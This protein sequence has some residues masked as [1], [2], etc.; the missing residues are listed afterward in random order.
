M[1]YKLYAGVVVALIVIAGGIYVMLAPSTPVITL[2]DHYDFAG[3]NVE[4]SGRVEAS[5][6]CKVQATLNEKPLM[7]Q[8]DGTFT[9]SL[10]VAAT[11]NTGK[12]EVKA[13]A[14]PLRLNSASK[15]AIA[16]ST[17]N[18]QPTLI[19]IVNPP[20]EWGTA[21]IEFKLRGAPGA[22]V[23]VQSSKDTRLVLDASGN[24]T[25]VVPFDTAYNVK[26]N[27]FIATAKIEGYANGYKAADV[28]NQKY[29]ADR[30]KL[31]QMA[32]DAKKQMESFSG[33]GNVRVAVYHDIVE[34]NC[35]GYSCVNNPDSAKF[36]RIAI[37]VLNAGDRS[38]YV[39]PLY[40]TLRS[41]DGETYT[42]NSSTYSLSKPM[43]SVALQPGA[44]T[45]GA[46]AFIVGRSEK[47]FTLIYTSPD[48]SVAKPIVVQ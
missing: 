46:L 39:N 29:D 19:D 5:C 7:L 35:I 30:T 22:S 16:H 28:K 21:K 3:E 15:V 42:H 18:R 14:Q 48:G 23:T 47:V 31:E 1:K 26:S 41:T 4:V 45:T 9:M 38:I 34:S 27:N 17:Y 37:K 11:D 36:I 12:I 43:E 10:P 32:E 2:Q 6:R 33:N 24:G 8:S 20:M 13:T 44:Y 25:A 40:V